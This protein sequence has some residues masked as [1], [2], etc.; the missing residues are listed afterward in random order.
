[1]IDV[2]NDR[3]HRRGQAGFTPAPRH[4]RHLFVMSTP[5]CVTLCQAA[6]R[7]TVLRGHR[8]GCSIG[9][10]RRRQRPSRHA[11]FQPA[12]AGVEDR[13]P[14]RPVQSPA[15]R[16][17]PSC[18]RLADNDDRRCPGRVRRR[19]VASGDDGNAE[20]R[21]VAGSTMF[22]AGENISV[23]PGRS[24]GATPP[25]PMP[26]KPP[27]GTRASDAVSTARHLPDA[28]DHG[29]PERGRPGFRLAGHRRDRAS[30]CRRLASRTPDRRRR[31]GAG[32]VRTTRRARRAGRCT[33][34][35]RQR[36][37][38]AGATARMMTARRP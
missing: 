21:E 6:D 13:E 34:S 11:L 26:S 9:Y 16:P 37:R 32:R 7:R 1:M 14:Q 12:V 18:E 22:Q 29:P 28:I 24:P 8:S 10:R 4:D 38:S 5:Q 31:R 17:E 25:R 20:R 15:V 19:E 23:V 33:R 36:T 30:R 35:V 2:L 3:R 27:G